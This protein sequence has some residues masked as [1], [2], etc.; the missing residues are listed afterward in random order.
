MLEAWMGC[1][2]R[3]KAAVKPTDLAA[4]DGTESASLATAIVGRASVLVGDVGHGVYLPFMDWSLMR[5]RLAFWRP[6]LS[7]AADAVVAAVTG[8]DA[9][10]GE[11]PQPAAASWRLCAIQ[12]HK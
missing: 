6:V 8:V 3:A 5:S 9:A 10:N 11:F 7:L 2:A 4:I 1:T 12:Y